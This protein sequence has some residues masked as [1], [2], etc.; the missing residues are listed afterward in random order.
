ML[1]QAFL[2][3]MWM[4]AI[5]NYTAPHNIILKTRVEFIGKGIEPHELQESHFFIWF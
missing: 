3:I 5:L 1:P 2:K 4:L